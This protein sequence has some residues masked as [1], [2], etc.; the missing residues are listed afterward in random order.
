MN[1]VRI[2]AEIA[3]AAEQRQRR[4]LP[5]KELIVRPDVTSGFHEYTDGSRRFDDLITAMCFVTKEA[6]PVLTILFGNSFTYKL[7]ARRARFEDGDL[8]PRHKHN[9]VE[10]T[11]V[12][13]GRY[14]QRIEGCDETLN[15]GEICLIGRDTP[16]REYLYQQNAIV[17][18]LGISN[19]FFDKSTPLET[20]D[21]EGQRFLREM[22]LNHDEKYHF[23]RFTPQKSETIIP[24][25]FEA[26]VSELRR[27]E[28]GTRYVVMGYAAR[29]LYRLPTDYDAH[30]QGKTRQGAAKQQF[31]DVKQ[32]LNEHYRE[33]SLEE[34]VSV[35]GYTPDYFNR[36][37][38]RR[39][40][41]TYSRFLQDIRLEKAKIL[42]KTTQFTIEDIAHQVGYENQ[43]YFYRI[44]HE[45]F[46]A[47]PDGLRRADPAILD[48]D[49]ILDSENP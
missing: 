14:H 13:E 43:T 16:H 20:G 27:H 12:V 44:F 32:Y 1:L 47:K 34:L 3:D 2:I 21:P 19:A 25:L 8:T 38:K 7:Q 37:I 35:F 6:S 40:G 9:Y 11:Y 29:L 46:S 42:L 4:I 30:I 5:Y 15:K 18:F 45:K 39:T 10:L 23:V 24:R 26:I 22:I 49:V 17:L 28:P 48:H 31:E 33:T 41:M 36:L